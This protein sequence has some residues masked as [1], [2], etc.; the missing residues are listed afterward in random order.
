MQQFYSSDVVQVHEV[1][2]RELHG[3][4]VRSLQ[5]CDCSLHMERSSYFSTTVIWTC[6]VNLATFCVQHCSDD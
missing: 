4:S 5:P 6:M 1:V 3:N 2:S